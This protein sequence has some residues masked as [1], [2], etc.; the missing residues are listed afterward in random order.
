MVDDTDTTTFFA[1]E[2]A[3]VALL[4]LPGV[5]VLAVVDGSDEQ[6]GVGGDPAAAAVVPGLRGAGAVEGSAGHQLRHLPST[7]GKPT[8]VVWVKREWRCRT[9]RR[10]W[11]ET[12]ALMRPR[13]TITEPARA[14][15]ARRVGQEGRAVAAV[16]RDFGVGWDLVWQAV[17]AAAARLFAEQGIY[18]TK[19]GRV[20]RWGWT[21]RT[22]CGPPGGGDAGGGRP[23]CWS[24]WTAAKCWMWS[25]NARR[26]PFRRGCVP[27][28][29]PG[30]AA[31]KLG[32][33]ILDSTGSLSFIGA[34]S[35]RRVSP[36][37]EPPPRTCPAPWQLALSPAPRRQR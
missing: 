32:A 27:R 33:R 11:R 8:R 23:P 22:G 25:R 7:T 16:A 34:A 13:A 19:L 9:C 12:H 6:Q 15:A 20:A 21:R 24:I 14:E 2:V 28:S 37:S 17:Q 18:T 30:A 35:P 3:A 31:D 29:R 26:R 5:R 36:W 1:G 4:G 10:S